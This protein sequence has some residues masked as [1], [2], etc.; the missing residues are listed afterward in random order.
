[1]R[2]EATLSHNAL[3][4]AAARHLADGAV[5][6]VAAGLSA[7]RIAGTF[8]IDGAPMTVIVDDVPV[9]VRLLDEGGKV[10]LNEAPV[11]LLQGLLVATGMPARDA[12]PI[13]AAIIARREGRGTAGPSPTGARFESLGQLARVAGMT[14]GLFRALEPF[15]TIE[16]RQPAIDPWVAPATVLAAVPG[17]DPRSVEALVRDRPPLF[18]G[19]D[20]GRLPVAA[21]PLLAPSATTAIGIEA[22]AAVNGLRFT[23]RAVINPGRDGGQ[24][25]LLSWR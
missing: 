14:P 12:A 15:I 3:D 21:N 22:N 18:Q 5:H 20:A 4:G 24:S 25:T 19:K 13:A 16:S 17:L 1:V 8:R 23:R 11:A 9:E 6:L 7:P 2:R 10:D